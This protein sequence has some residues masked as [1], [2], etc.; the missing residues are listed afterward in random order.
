MNRSGIDAV[1]H[2][3][4]RA[5]LHTLLV[6]YDFSEPAEVALEYAIELSR[7]FGSLV[8]VVYV[9]SAR[10]FAAEM[11]SGFRMGERRREIESEM[12]SLEQRLR[13]QNV[14]HQVF[15]RSGVIADV[16]IREAAELHADLVILGA[17][18]SRRLDPPRLGSTAEA[19]IKTMSCGVMVIGPEMMMRGSREIVPMRHVLYVVQASQKLHLARFAKLLAQKTSVQIEI[20]CA[21]SER[22]TQT[23]AHRHAQLESHCSDLAEQMRTPEL[24][25]SWKLL[26]GPCDRAISDR[27]R[28]IHA[29]LILFD[30]EST[31]EGSFRKE[32]VVSNAIQ[33]APCPVL[34]MPQHL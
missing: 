26:H 9:Q 24:S 28:E 22:G 27:A 3:A 15:H 13:E 20:A 21:S 14:Q 17:Y 34:I 32:E 5:F 10:E 11:E 19:M 7:H 31:C 18:G 8:A 25:V 23:D 6:A 1:Q 29:N 12:H 30:H 33:Q 2:E 4:H 16:L